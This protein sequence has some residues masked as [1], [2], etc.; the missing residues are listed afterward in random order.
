VFCIGSLIFSANVT[1]V[2]RAHRI[3]LHEA[4]I[5]GIRHA[6]MGVDG[7]AGVELDEQMV[8]VVPNGAN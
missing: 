4:R 2:I 6:G 8:A 3:G 1:V 5:K 7:I